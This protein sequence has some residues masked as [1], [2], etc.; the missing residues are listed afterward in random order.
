MVEDAGAAAVAVHGRT[1]AQSYSRPGRLGP[2]RRV[3]RGVRIPV[4]GSG[5]CVEPE[6]IVARLATGVS[7]VLV[8]RGV[9]RN[10]WILAQAA[11]L[12]AGRAPRAV[13]RWPSAA[14]S[15][16]TT[17]TCCSTSARRSARLPP[18][19]AGSGGADV[20]RA[21][22]RPRALGDQ[23]AARAVHLVHEGPRG[24]VA[25]ADAVNSAESLDQ[26]REIIDRF[27]VAE[28]A[29]AAA[30]DRPRPH[31]PP[32]RVRHGRHGCR[33]AHRVA[34]GVG[35]SVRPACAARAQASASAAA[36]P[37]RAPAAA[38][39]AARR[40]SPNCR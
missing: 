28:P 30:R 20:A 17:S 37:I 2:G 34:A 9:L 7:G 40:S 14:S 13:T 15:C 22:A 21:D 12:A 16:S 3:A 19:R 25:P 23:Q 35:A 29:A 32:R 27:F 33:H 38:G 31:E 24:R 5:D 4:F 10:P 6:Q 26:V 18:P 39:P 36:P 8:G 11:D 1:A